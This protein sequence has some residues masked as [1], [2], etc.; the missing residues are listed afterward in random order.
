M[1]FYPFKRDRSHNCKAKDPEFVKEYF[2]Q[3]WVPYFALKSVIDIMRKYEVNYVMYSLKIGI[4][5]AIVRNC[6]VES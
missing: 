6:K 2:V 1:R 5:I 3:V 4:G